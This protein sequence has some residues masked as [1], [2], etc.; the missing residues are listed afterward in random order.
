MR[1][2]LVVGEALIDLVPDGVGT[3]FSSPWE[4]QSA[5]GPLNSAVALARLGRRVAFGGPISTD[6]FGA[7]LS[8]HLT[9]N[10]VAVDRA[11]YGA[12]P[13]ALAVLSLDDAGK[14]SY[15]FHVAGTASFDPD[16]AALPLAEPGEW[17]HLAS[18]VLL[19]P[20]IA[21]RLLERY[22]TT[23]GPVSLDLNVRPAIEP[24]PAR[25][26]ARLQPWLTWLG[27]RRGVLK[28]SDDDFAF[29]ALGSGDPD[30]AALS[31][32][33][34]DTGSFDCVVTT[35][36]PAGARAEVSG[37]GLVEVAG[38]PTDVVDTV[39]AGDTFMAGFLDR[40]SDHGAEEDALA[41]A[42]RRGVAAA[43]V[44]VARRGAQPP[45]STEVDSVLAGEVAP[46]GS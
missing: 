20:P 7:Q 37:G 11:P 40:W 16:P 42:L 29:L 32:R 8:R 39:G 5:G 12:G 18:M 45:T 4:A 35:L 26:W 34:A 14:A 27:A 19:V 2:F 6:A 36:G 17:L 24:D 28:A 9:D 3:T 30:G 41:A 22:G 46:G 23:A 25:Y 38:L 13:T 10:R 31:R 15:H 33:L 21:E 1:S 44:V 43:S